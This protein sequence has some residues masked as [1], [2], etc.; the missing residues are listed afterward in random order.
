MSKFLTADEWEALGVRRQRAAG[1]LTRSE[2]ETSLSFIETERKAEV[3]TSN[4][5]WMKR[6]EG[7]GAVPESIQTYAIGD[8]QFRWYIVP[9]K[10]IKKPYKSQFEK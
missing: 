8:G 2:R 7:C 1:E 3:N 9:K 5:A 4:I 10:W 6:L